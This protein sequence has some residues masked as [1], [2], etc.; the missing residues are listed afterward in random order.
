MFMAFIIM[1]I[2]SVKMMIL[3][4]KNNIRDGLFNCRVGRGSHITAFL[5]WQVSSDPTVVSLHHQQDQE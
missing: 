3:I 5:P 4:I 2:K 1:I